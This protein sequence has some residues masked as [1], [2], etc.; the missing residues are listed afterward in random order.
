MIIKIVYGKQ[1]HLFNGQI[2]IAALKAHC[3]KVFKSI[4]TL[5]DFFYTDSDGDEIT[6]ST[7]H[8]AKMLE[9]LDVQEARS[10]KK[11]HIRE[12]DEEFE[13]LES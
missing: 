4:P 8:D 6:I 13:L 7:E 11:I 10:V 1:I 5:Y 2:S 9:C 12:L 3:D